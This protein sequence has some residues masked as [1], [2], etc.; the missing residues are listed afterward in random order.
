MG[1][2]YGYFETLARAGIPLPLNEETVKE[3][4]EFAE[5]QAEELKAKI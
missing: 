5:K 3:T 1:G 4:A 2:M